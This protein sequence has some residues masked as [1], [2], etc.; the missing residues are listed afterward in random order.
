MAL[1]AGDKL[2]P[3]EIL[4]LIGAGGMGEV[5][6]ARDPKLDRHVAIKVLPAALAQHPDR[7]ARFEREAKV[8]AA[9][10][11]PNIA[12]IYGIEDRAIVMELVEGPTLADRITSGAL[13]LEEILKIVA[14]IADAMEAAHDKG[15]VHRDLKPANV[16]VRDDGTVKVLDFGLATAVQSSTREAGSQGA[17]GVNSPTLTMGATEAGVIMGTASY[18]SPEQAAGKPVDRRADIWSFGAVLWEM[19]TGSRLFS[20]ETVSHTLADVLRADIDYARLP[21]STPAPIRELLRRC[22]DRDPKTRLRDIGEARIAIQKY[23]LNPSSTLETSLALAPRSHFAV[24]GWA[25]AGL[26]AVAMA[27]GWRALRP[28]DPVLQPLIRLDVDLGPD[29]SLGSSNGTDVIISPDGTRLVYVSQNRLFTRRLDQATATELKGTE[30]ASAPFF[31]PNGQWVAFFSGGSLQKVSIDGGTAVVLCPAAT[32]RGGSWAEDDSIIASIGTRLMRVP[33]AGGEPAAL[34]EPAPGGLGQ[35]SPQ[36]LPGG[37]AVLFTALQ[38]SQTPSVSVLSLADHRIKTLQNGG[39]FG[40][41]LASG[42]LIYVGTQ[43][44]LFAAAFDLDKLQM[45]G[46]PVPVL[47]LDPVRTVSP[48]FDVSGN[49]TAVYRK[50]QGSGSVTIQWLD[51]AGKMQPLLTKPGFYGRPTIS[52]V[53]ERLVLEVTEGQNTDLW[54]YDWR[55]DTMAPLTFGGN[56]TIPLWSPDGRY[57]VFQKNQ[58]AIYWTRSDGASQPQPLTESK[59]TQFP[60]SFTSDGKRLALFQR[61]STGTND[62]FTLPIESNAGG[63]RAGKAEAFV[64]TP[65]DERYPAFSP[66]GRWLAY[67]SNEKGTYEVY[68]KAFP[69]KGGKWQV[70]N[71]GGAYPMWSRTGHELFF[72]T[73]DQKIMAA[74]YTT[75]GDSFVPDKPRLWSEQK[76]IGLINSVRNFDLVP[77][78]K[79]IAALMPAATPE[80]HQA[81]NH[82]VFLMNFF[83]EIRRRVPL[84][85]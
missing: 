50:G 9:L 35:F 27:L 17:E 11:H 33:A 16:K 1:A 67:T 47:E 24:A 78:G 18:M 45:R 3:Y 19:L 65:A 82:V 29:V 53:D 32:S 74:T 37:K 59:V 8:L 39:A 38:G 25:V 28:A 58:G 40:R 69:D 5:Y 52:P 63:L 4:A 23:L 30:G 43:G 2:G 21:A 41:Y 14:Q 73:F 20:G 83:D 36:V 64:Q 85:K 26:L 49:G 44:T 70:S 12:V 15:V 77:D 10:N 75:K 55:R 34:T 51:S 54:V 57:I 72:E 31:S 62:L 6:R 81:Q 42:H 7:L 22:L 56:N 71:G 66:D 61:G 13:P 79:R 46:N 80:G 68:V 76:L 60:H 48:Q 84:S